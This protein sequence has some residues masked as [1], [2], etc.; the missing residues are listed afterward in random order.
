[1][2]RKNENIESFLHL[3]LVDGI[4]NQVLENRKS[5]RKKNNLY[6]YIVGI[7]PS[8]LVRNQLKFIFCERF[9]NFSQIF[10]ISFF[11]NSLY[12]YDQITKYFK[13]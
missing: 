5:M 9:I 2:I 4:K 6:V 10:K 3:K 8:N 11:I 7:L 1:M 12:E 13:I